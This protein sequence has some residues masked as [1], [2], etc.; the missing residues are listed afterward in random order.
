VRSLAGREGQIL[1]Q[2]IG[3]YQDVGE[4][5]RAVEAEAADRLERDFGRGVAVVN[6]REEPAFVRPQLAIFREITAGLT[7]QPHRRRPDPLAFQHSDQ[8]LS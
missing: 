5:D 1:A 7:H 4:Q 2:R 6:E 3:N 8:W